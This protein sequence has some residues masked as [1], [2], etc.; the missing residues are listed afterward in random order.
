MKSAR[1]TKAESS[2]AVESSVDFM[3]TSNPRHLRVL[4]ALLRRPLSREN[5]DTIAGCSNG[6]DLVNELRARGLA[7]PCER[8]R[9]EDRDGNTCRPGVYSLS[10]DDHKKIR[11][12]QARTAK[13][14]KPLEAVRGLFEGA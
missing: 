11:R 2:A 8:I 9:V 4:T 7:L 3:G 12:W 14:R 1:P 5:L 13:S 10:E 6:P